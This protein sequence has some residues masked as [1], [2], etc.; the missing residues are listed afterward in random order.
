MPARIVKPEPEDRDA[1]WKVLS[2]RTSMDVRRRA[3]KVVDAAHRSRGV[4]KWMMYQWMFEVG[5]VE[6]ERIYKDSGVSGVS[7]ACMAHREKGEG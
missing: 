6:V 5:L 1:A 4:A 2:F 7:R 3:E